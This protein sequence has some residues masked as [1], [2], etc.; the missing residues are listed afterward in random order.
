MEI[1]PFSEM[2]NRENIHRW[3]VFWFQFLYIYTYGGK[4]PP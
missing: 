3:D 4:I 1:A 2:Y